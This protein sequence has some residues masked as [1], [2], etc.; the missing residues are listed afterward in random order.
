MS[1]QVSRTSDVL[2][3][4]DSC[5]RATPLLL[6]FILSSSV[7]AG[8]KPCAAALRYRVIAWALSRVA[9]R[10]FAYARPRLSLGFVHFFLAKIRDYRK[11][12]VVTKSNYC[13]TDNS[14][15]DS[16]GSHK[17]SDRPRLWT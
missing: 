7:C 8:A 5:Y 12:P 16:L 2:P 4:Q 17:I 3:I 11:L 9:P 6:D 10:P 13:H 14:P 15:G 1:Y